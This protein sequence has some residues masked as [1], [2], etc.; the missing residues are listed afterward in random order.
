MAKADVTHLPNAGGAGNDTF[1]F[2]A[3]F[4]SDTVAAAANQDVI[5]FSTAV[6]ANVAAVQGVMQ[7]VGTD[8]MI[9][10]SPTE[11]I[12]LHGIALSALDATDFLFVRCRGALRTDRT[13]CRR[14]RARA[15][16]DRTFRQCLSSCRRRVRQ[17]HVFAMVGGKRAQE[18]TRLDAQGVGPN[19][20]TAGG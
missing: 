4:G 11:V 1:V 5:E 12:T 16:R 17:D 8:V 2:A 3:G 20:I 18:F 7:Q 9:T 10:A 13:R 14:C 19:P 15:G 6:F